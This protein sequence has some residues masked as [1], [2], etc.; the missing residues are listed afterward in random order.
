MRCLTCGQEYGGWNV[1]CPQ[2]TNNELLEKQNRILQNQ[3]SYVAPSGGESLIWIAL[4]VI[5]SVISTVFFPDTWIG[6]A[7]SLVW[8]LIFIPFKIIWTML[9]GG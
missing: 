2:C 1:K 4:F 9:G 5:V 7:L 8:S 6:K 3:S